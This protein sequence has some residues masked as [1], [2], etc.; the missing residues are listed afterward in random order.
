MIVSLKDKM[1]THQQYTDTLQV[2]SCVRPA[3]DPQIG[4]ELGLIASASLQVIK[5]FCVKADGKDKLTALVQV[6]DPSLEA[7]VLIAEGFQS[8]CTTEPLSLFRSISAC[9]SQLESLVI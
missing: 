3:C 1:L 6:V 2:L 4:A 8:C 9:S 7:M 5:G